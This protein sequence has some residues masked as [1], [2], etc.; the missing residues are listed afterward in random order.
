MLPLGDTV[1]IVNNL[2]TK[3]RAELVATAAVAYITG[4]KLIAA[5]NIY[6][7]YQKVLMKRAPYIIYK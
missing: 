5:V 6:I 3:D 4:K 2:N 7:E 1:P